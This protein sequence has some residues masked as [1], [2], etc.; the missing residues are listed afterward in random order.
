MITPCISASPP[1]HPHARTR[2][3]L[4]L[5][6][7][8]LGDQARGSQ[9]AR[10]IQEPPLATPYF[11][12]RR[13]WTRLRPTEAEALA[14]LVKLVWMGHPK[15]VERCG[16]SPF[17]ALASRL[18]SQI[19]N[20]LSFNCQK[21]AER[22][23]RVLVRYTQLGRRYVVRRPMPTHSVSA[24]GRDREYIAHFPNTDEFPCPAPLLYL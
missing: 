14:S 24:D 10:L 20:N 4:L 23:D 17:T 11:P 18:S 7:S 15:V 16:A 2:G 22:V 5:L 19:P 9:L 3:S 21:A 8:S 1:L 13:H 12:H 6:R